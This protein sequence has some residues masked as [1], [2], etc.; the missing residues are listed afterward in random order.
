MGAGY[1]PRR[2]SFKIFLRGQELPLLWVILGH[3]CR[4]ASQGRGPPSASVEN[5]E[6]SQGGSATRGCGGVAA[7]GALLCVPYPGGPKLF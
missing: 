6:L 1:S 3:T 2:L 4:E 7:G 5:L